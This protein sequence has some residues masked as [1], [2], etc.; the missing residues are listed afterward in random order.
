MSRAGPSSESAAILY[1]PGCRE[2][3]EDLGPDELIRRLKVRRRTEGRPGVLWSLIVGA[4][5]VLSG[6]CM[7]A[8][9]GGGGMNMNRRRPGPLDA[10][11][12]NN[13]V[14]FSKRC[15]NSWKWTYLAS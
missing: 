15:R 11:S 12:V 4:V 7:E 13:G 14:L 3:S 2:I 8:G 10:L 1:P 6:V 9:G 5:T